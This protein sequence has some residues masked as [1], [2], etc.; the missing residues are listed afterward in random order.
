MNTERIR[1]FIR[2]IRE[3]RGYG[4]RGFPRQHNLPLGLYLDR[5]LG[6][7]YDSVFVRPVRPMGDDWMRKSAGSSRDS[8]GGFRSD[9]GNGG[10]YEHQRQRELLF[11]GPGR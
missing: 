4:D 7:H 10:G 6:E 8:Q 9:R 5:D 2:G 1:D 3:I 11:G